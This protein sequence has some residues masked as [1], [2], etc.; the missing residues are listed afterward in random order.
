LS[1]ASWSAD[2]TATGLSRSDGSV[3]S[4]HGVVVVVVVLGGGDDDVVVVVEGV[5]VVEDVDDAAVALDDVA[6]ESS[7]L[8]SFDP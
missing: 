2:A 3:R 1:E 4:G 8:S 6:D 7:V 5:D